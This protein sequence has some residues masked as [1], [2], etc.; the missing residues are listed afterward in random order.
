MATSLV[1]TSGTRAT[2]LTLLATSMLRIS[3]STFTPFRWISDCSV[4][5]LY[6]NA[7]NMRSN[8]A[9]NPTSFTSVSTMLRSFIA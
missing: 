5:G 8:P 7:R 4:L 1:L 3:F 6:L 2:R 9:R